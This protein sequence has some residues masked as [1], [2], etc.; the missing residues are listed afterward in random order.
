[1]VNFSGVDHCV[2]RSVVVIQGGIGSACSTFPG[3]SL[4]QNYAYHLSDM[5]RLF[6][7]I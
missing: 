4:F 6:S 1:M 2:G 3:L 7:V 5:T